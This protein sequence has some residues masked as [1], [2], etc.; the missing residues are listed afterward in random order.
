MPVFDFNSTPDENKKGEVTY[1]TFASSE[2][3]ASKEHPIMFLDNKNR[4]WKHH[5]SGVFT[6]P[7]KKLL[8]NL[9]KRTEQLAL[10]F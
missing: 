9:M 10:I 2:S 4:Q 1:T 5:S 8:L 3:I 7:I 6:N